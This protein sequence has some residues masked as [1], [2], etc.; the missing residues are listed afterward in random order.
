MAGL[1]LSLGDVNQMKASDRKML[2]DYVLS[3]LSTHPGAFGKHGQYDAIFQPGL[4][5]EGGQPFSEFYRCR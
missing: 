5:A 3:E 1:T 4:A 2:F